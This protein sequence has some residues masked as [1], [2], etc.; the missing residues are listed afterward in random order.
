MEGVHYFLFDLLRLDK[1]RQLRWHLTRQQLTAYVAAADRTCDIYIR[2]QLWQLS[3]GVAA[4]I[5]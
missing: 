3:N 5:E 2:P 4:D 1:S